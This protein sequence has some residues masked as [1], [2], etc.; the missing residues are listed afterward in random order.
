MATLFCN[1][2]VPIPRRS[3]DRGR[4]D[5]PQSSTPLPPLTGCATQSQ[6]LNLSGFPVKIEEELYA[7]HRVVTETVVQ[8]LSCVRLS[9]TPWTAARQA[10]LSI[11]NSRSLLQLMSMELVMPSN[12]H[13]LCCPLLLLPSV[14]PSIREDS[15]SERALYIRWPK[16]QRFSL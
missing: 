11:T 1:H 7:F 6:L 9:A 10:S 15:S 4:A 12:H 8:S 16:Y 2:G 14:F 13:I 5:A 3:Q